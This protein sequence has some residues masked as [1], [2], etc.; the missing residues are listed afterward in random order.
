MGEVTSSNGVTVEVEVVYFSISAARRLQASGLAKCEDGRLEFVRESVRPGEDPTSAADRVLR[1]VAGIRAAVYKPELIGAFAHPYRQIDGPV[2]TL[3]FMVFGRIEIDSM[4]PWDHFA[5]IE[6]TAQEG[7]RSPHVIEL[8]LERLRAL[9]FSTP[10]AGRVAANKYGLFTLKELRRVFEAVLGEQLDP[11]NFRR[12]AEAI[13]GLLVERPEDQ[14][15]YPE[16][17]SYRDLPRGRGRR[18][19]VYRVTHDL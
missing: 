9:V 11:A 19:I 2:V 8:A 16:G 14:S 10:I 4:A 15:L 18:P 7:F 1:E 6:E 5:I 13:E 17:S 3:S 12:R